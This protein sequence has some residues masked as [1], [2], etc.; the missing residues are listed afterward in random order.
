MKI[1]DEL[2]AWCDFYCDR[3]IYKSDFE[4]LRYLADR[5]DEEMV[6]LPRD[7]DG[8]PIH[9][10]DLVYLDDGRRACAKAIDIREDYVLIACW[11]GI[12]YVA[13]PPSDITHERQYS[14]ERIADE[15]DE[16]VDAAGSADDGCEKLADLA[17]RIRK[18]AKKEA[19]HGGR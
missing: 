17:D 15:L 8:V 7:A 19:E 12:R 9:M 6:E 4:K 11:D 3:P 14:W 2:H 16:M 5:I 10:N 1:S 18:L 13:Y